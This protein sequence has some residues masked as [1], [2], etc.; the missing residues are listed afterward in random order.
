MVP[1]TAHVSVQKLWYTPY[2]IDCLETFIS[3]TTCYMY[4]S[5]L[6][7][8]YWPYILNRR[9][10]AVT[11]GSEQRIRSRNRVTQCRNNFKIANITFHMIVS[12]PLSL[13]IRILPYTLIIPLVLSS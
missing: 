3:K 9:R 7:T 2:N 13:H 11:A 12:I 10:L 4:V 5:T 1:V 6:S 8:V